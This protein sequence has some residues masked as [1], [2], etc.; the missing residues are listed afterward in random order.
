MCGL[1][2][3]YILLHSSRPIQSFSAPNMWSIRSYSLLDHEIFWVILIH[4]NC[5][6]FSPTKSQIVVSA[7]VWTDHQDH[8]VHAIKQVE[9]GLNKLLA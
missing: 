4:A 2:I 5:I 1:Y 3:I 8:L 7:L 6:E 9:R